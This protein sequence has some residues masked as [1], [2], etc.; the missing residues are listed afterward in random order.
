MTKTLAVIICVLTFFCG[1]VLNNRGWIGLLPITASISYTIIMY[2]AKS[3]Q[4]MQI[5]VI[6]NMIQWAIFSIAPLLFRKL[7]T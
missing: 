2:K 7:K 3:I 6:I 5:A 1:L 4:H